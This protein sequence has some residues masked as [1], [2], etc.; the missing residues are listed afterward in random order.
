MNRLATA[1]KSHED[2]AYDLNWKFMRLK[3]SAYTGLINLF[4][5]ND[6]DHI[7]ILNY[8]DCF[9]MDVCNSSG[10]AKATVNVKEIR[11]SSSYDTL[12]I[13]DTDDNVWE[14]CDW[15]TNIVVVYSEATNCLA[16]KYNDYDKL[17]TGAKVRW[18]DPGIEDYD[19]EDREDILQRVFVIYDCP[20]PDE[21]E[22][23]TVIGITNEYTEAEVNAYELVFVEQI[24][25]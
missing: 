7:D 16:A 17:H 3:E 11:Y 1:I 20:N 24:L 8:H 6:I 14:D 21:I 13:I 5:E 9:Y 2:N 23:D 25:D 15:L 19:P 10:Y 22:N 4:R 18:I 12:S